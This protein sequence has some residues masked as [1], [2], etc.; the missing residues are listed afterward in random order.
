M[1]SKACE[2]GIK[3]VIY[4]ATQSMDGRRS[5]LGDIAQNTG[6]PEAF[7][8]KILGLLSRNNLITSLTG[9]YG[10]FNIDIDQMMKTTLSDIVKAIDGDAIFNGCGLGLSECNNEYPCPMHEK[11]VTVRQQ[12]REML[13]QTTIYELAT[14]LKNGKTVLLR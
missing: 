7:T 11:F 4:I 2:H 13:T 14:G 12:I 6:T 10:G 5:K 9:P 1:F 8:A 3:A